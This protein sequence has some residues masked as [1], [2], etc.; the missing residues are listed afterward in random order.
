MSTQAQSKHRVFCF[1]THKKVR[2][3]RAP[4]HG[5]HAHPSAAL[6]S[7]PP[8]K[9]T[10]QK[11][12]TGFHKTSPS[13]CRIYPFVQKPKFQQRKGPTTNSQLLRQHI[14]ANVRVKWQKGGGWKRRGSKQSFLPFTK[15][16]NY[17]GEGCG[18]SWLLI[19]LKPSHS[20]FILV[21]N[22]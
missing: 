19:S 16:G 3:K 5:V 11:V 13:F 9:H 4:A 18:P 14:R 15:D 21:R 20:R 6:S 2:T 12:T 10:P 7:F 8:S 1:L 17:F 22:Y